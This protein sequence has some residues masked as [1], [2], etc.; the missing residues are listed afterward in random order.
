MTPSM[1]PAIPATRIELKNILFTTDFSDAANAAVP[2]VKELAKRFGA[3]VH[4][5]HVR[6][7]AVNPMTQPSSWAGLEEAARIE[8]E[9]H[10]Q[11]LRDTFA[12]MEP[13]ITIEE[14]DLGSN[15]EPAIERGHMDMI[16]MGTRGRTG[17]G[18]F[19][20][21]SVA[22]KVFRGAS[23]PVFTV[24]PHAITIGKPYERFSRILFA[25]DFSHE[26][27]AALKY[28]ISLAEEYQAHLTLL[29]VV[30]EEKPG[31]IVLPADLTAAAEQE[32]R[33]LVPEE[34]KDWCVPEYKV[35]VGPVAETIL[36]IA[37]H[38]HADLIV[39]GMNQPSAFPGAD[40]HLSIRTAHKVVSHAECPVLTV[41]G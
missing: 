38:D 24:G 9:R 3:K 11:E 16:V 23:C 21:G 22:E 29:H 27:K 37:A 15:L 14:G 5:L 13:E 1:K 34:A 40:E 10:R 41:R 39:M 19:F 26:S 31:E 18:K 7:P 36:D 20:L 4:A 33:T 32:I 28:A 25:T 12:G 17:I 30:E 8:N 6:T 35:A 2:Y